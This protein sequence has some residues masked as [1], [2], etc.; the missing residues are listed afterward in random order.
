MKCIDGAVLLL[1]VPGSG[2]T[3]VLVTRL[4]YMVHCAGIKPENILTMTYTKSA[5]EEM[6]ARFASLYGDEYAGEM[7]F[8]TIN[9]LSNQIIQY[10]SSS[11]YGKRKP[12]DVADEQTTAMIIGRMYKQ[13]NDDYA[14]DSVI[15]EIKTAITY[16]KNMMLTDEEIAETDFGI[17]NMS[18]I[19]FR[20]CETL[21]ANGLMD[22]DDQMRFALRVLRRYPKILE[23]Y[24]ERYRY[25]CVDE[26]QDTSKLQHEIIKLLASKYGNIFMVGDED[27]SIYGFRAAYPDA[28]LNFQSDY[29]NAKVL[30]MEH[31]YRSTGEIVNTAN[32]FIARNKLRHPKIIR[33]T[34]GNGGPIRVVYAS[35]RRAQYLYLFELAKN[36]K[37]S[38]CCFAIMKVRCH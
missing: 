33:P 34:N 20:Y 23:L 8:C 27:Q 25:I 37:E 13:V 21:E 1:A 17:N 4:G 16:I 35:N 15:K 5:T 36:A 7:K 32:S 38:L 30:L 10:Y 19:Y 3:T 12:F 26:A 2:K 24:Q 9:S 6:R 11:G 28:L 18:Q 31:N 22:Y 29:S 14:T